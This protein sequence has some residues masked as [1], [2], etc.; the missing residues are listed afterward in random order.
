MKFP[1]LANQYF[2]EN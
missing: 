2:K 1:N